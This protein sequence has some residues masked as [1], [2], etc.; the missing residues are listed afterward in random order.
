MRSLLL[1]P[2]LA[3]LALA[4]GGVF[5]GTDDFSAVIDAPAVVTKGAPFTVTITVMNTANE[6]QR[7]DSLDIDDAWLQGLTLTASSPPYK[8]AMHVPIDNT[9]SYSYSELIPAGGSSTITLTATGVQT[10]TFR[11]EVDV[12][13]G[14][15]A[16]FRSYPL[17]TTV[18]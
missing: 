16:R 3:A 13:V 11:G 18:E 14:G 5:E 2:P 8:E 17:V 12:C 7:L 4:C 6:P 9:W 1:L 10:G 15:M